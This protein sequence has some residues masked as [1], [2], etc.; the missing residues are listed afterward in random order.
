MELQLKTIFLIMDL[1]S[2]YR[3]N[4]APL[5]AQ[6]LSQPSAPKAASR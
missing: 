4:I 2:S 1:N 3:L 6:Q 5:I